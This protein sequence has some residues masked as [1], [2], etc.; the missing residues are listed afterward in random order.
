MTMNVFHGG[1]DRTN[2]E[3][4]ERYEIIVVGDIEKKVFAPLLC[5]WLG[6]GRFSVTSS[7]ADR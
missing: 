4:R 5:K 3:N 6:Y 7:S 1:A 2:R